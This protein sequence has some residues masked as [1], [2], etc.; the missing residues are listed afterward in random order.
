MSRV[1]LG[2][3]HQVQQSQQLN[4]R[5]RHT[6][7]LC[8]TVEL[9][10]VDC[11]RFF[12]LGK[13]RRLKPSNIKE[14]VFS[15]QYFTRYKSS[16]FTFS[17]YMFVYLFHF[18]SVRWSC[19]LGDKTEDRPIKVLPQQMPRVY[20]WASVGKSRQKMAKNTANFYENRKNHGKITAKTRHQTTGPK[21]IIQSIKLK[22]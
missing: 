16:M 5:R 2:M 9:E 7:S 12:I 3:F 15:E 6:A 8:P 4:F 18:I 10:M 19:W 11:S 21:T 1:V 20:C 17:L 22:I 13:W 14:V